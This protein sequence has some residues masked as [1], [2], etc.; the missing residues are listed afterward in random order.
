MS[1]VHNT[2]ASSTADHGSPSWMRRTA[3]MAWKTLLIMLGLA[4]GIVFA[5]TIA[6]LTGLIS[7]AC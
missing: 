2:L 7:L 1:H 4:I 6:L 3:G 5:L